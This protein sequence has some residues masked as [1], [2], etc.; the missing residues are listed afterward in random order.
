MVIDHFG[1]N[2]AIF[3]PKNCLKVRGTPLKPLRFVGLMLT[4]VT[5]SIKGGFTP[6]LGQKWP[7]L[8]QNGH[9][10]SKMVIFALK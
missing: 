1:L 3:D 5:E 8:A 9:F 10:W 4:D 2:M 6:F 7:F